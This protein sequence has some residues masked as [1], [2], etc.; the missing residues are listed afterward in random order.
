V[1]DKICGRCYCQIRIYQPFMAL[2]VAG[3]QHLDY[4]DCVKEL[5][6]H[7]TELCA[8]IAQ[9]QAQ[10]QASNES[11]KLYLKEADKKNE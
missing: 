9:L 2:G 10:L 6:A 11:L 3:Y 5:K 7:I 8:E 1:S 4:W